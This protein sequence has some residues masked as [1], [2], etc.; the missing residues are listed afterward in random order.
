MDAL[1][2]LLLVWLAAADADIRRVESF[3]KRRRGGWEIKPRCHILY[4]KLDAE[5]LTKWWHDAK[6]SKLNLYFDTPNTP[7]WNEQFRRAIGV[8][9]HI[10]FHYY[11]LVE[12]EPGFGMR[13]DF[14]SSKGRPPQNLRMKVASWLQ[15]LRFGSSFYKAAIDC[16]LSEKVVRQNFHKLNTFLVESEYSK[17]VY[18]PVDDRLY[19]TFLHSK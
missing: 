3:R 13:D 11:T 1:M 4:N 2:L 5:G 8:P 10:F 6:L 14:D 12:H 15:V 18:I 19:L 16:C 9:R 17:H 7:Y